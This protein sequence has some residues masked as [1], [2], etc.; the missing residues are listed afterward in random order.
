MPKNDALKKVATAIKVAEAGVSEPSRRRS[1]S[2]A[3]QITDLTDIG[4]VAARVQPF[5]SDWSM[6]D[7]SAN[8][9]DMREKLRNNIAPSVRQAKNRVPGADYSVEVT[10]FAATTKMYVIAL[11]TRTA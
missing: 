11:V 4:H 9:S 6:D 7:I 8:M 5:P 10:S 2:F 1:S 3:S